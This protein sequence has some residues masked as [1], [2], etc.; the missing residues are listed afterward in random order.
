[1]STV[2]LNFP[3]LRLLAGIVFLL[4]ALFAYYHVP[5]GALGI[6]LVVAGI[7]V[8]AIPLA[9]HRP[10]GGDVALFVIALIV[11]AASASVTSFEGMN[12]VG[13]RVSVYS[14]SAGSLHATAVDLSVS[15]NLGSISIQSSTNSDLGYKVVFTTTSVF[16]LFPFAYNYS[17]TNETIGGTLFLN[18]TS[19]AA[20]ISITLGPEYFQNIV[21]TSNTGSVD[22]QWTTNKT[23]GSV[24]LSSNTGSVD[25]NVA[26]SGIREL[27]LSTNTGSVSLSSNYF[28]PAAT[29]VPV[30][31]STDTGSVSFDVSIPVAS[32]MSIQASNSVGSI[33]HDLA[34]FTI[35]QSSNNQLFAMYGNVDVVNSF[36]VIA[37]GSTGSISLSVHTF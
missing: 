12:Y 8:I 17:L 15:A 21:A 16:G 4:A 7:V 10:Q 19:R 11:M 26:T 22:L 1:V 29:R 32:A 20:A 14:V 23:L 28:V 34:G 37:S 18:A 3:L 27:S 13:T 2:E 5:L 30:T 24:T 9:G 36:V 25:A 35:S 6:V 33:S 31:L